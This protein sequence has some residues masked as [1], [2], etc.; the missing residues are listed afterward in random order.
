MIQ[1]LSAV[2]YEDPS[3]PRAFGELVEA[4]SQHVKEEESEYFPAASRTL[5]KTATE[6]M[7]ARYEA[8]KK[9]VM[10]EERQ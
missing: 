1:R 2:P 10:K 3:W 4:V 7:T 9:A 5:G 6:A 8:K